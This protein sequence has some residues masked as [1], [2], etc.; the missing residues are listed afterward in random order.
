MALVKHRVTPIEAEPPGDDGTG[1]QECWIADLASGDSATR[2]RAAHALS[3]MPD[4]VP[5]VC[6]HLANEQ[7]LSV[8]SIILTGLIINRSR[9]VVAGLLP[10][11]RSEDANLRNGAIEALQQMPDEVAPYVDA[12]LADADSDVRIFAVDV[13]AALPHPMVPEWLCRVVKSDPHVNVCAAALDALAEAGNPD[14]IP[15]LEELGGRFS[16][17]SFIRFAVNVAIR[18]IGRR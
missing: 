11:L 5:V 2:R 10:L 9:S 1:G 12:M 17:V 4:A 8:R 15:V 6:A 14:V 16:D 18:R 7:S 3:R 13:L